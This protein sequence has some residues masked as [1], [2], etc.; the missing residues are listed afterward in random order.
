MKKKKNKTK[1]RCIIK[2]ENKLSKF[3]YNANNNAL[4]NLSMMVSPPLV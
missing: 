1:S 3:D 4:L 2:L